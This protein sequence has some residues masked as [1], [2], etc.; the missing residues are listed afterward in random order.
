MVG[1][2]ERDRGRQGTEGEGRKSRVVKDTKA[3]CPLTTQHIG[4]RHLSHFYF[5][6]GVAGA[7][8]DVHLQDMLRTYYGPRVCL[9]Q[10]FSKFRVQ[11]ESPE[12][13]NNI[14]IP[15]AGFLTLHNS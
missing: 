7:L 6:R 14:L 11:K 4:L 2:K 12:G 8:R 10:W 1:K 3:P 15:A 5:F 13:P 9:G